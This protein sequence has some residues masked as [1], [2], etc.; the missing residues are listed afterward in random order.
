MK[1]RTLVSIGVALMLAQTCASAD[2]DLNKISLPPGFEIA[3]FADDV[4]N[5]RQMAWGESGT[6]FV[7]SRD[8]GTVYAV[9]DADGDGSA[10]KTYKIAKGLN[11]PSG[12]AFRQGSLYVAAVSTI[13][14]FDDIEAQLANPPKPVVVTDEF[15]SD[16]HHGWKYL[17]FGPDDKLYVPVGAP[18]NVCDEAGYSAIY[19]MDSDGKNREVYAEG[20]RNS[21]GFDWHPETQ[22]FWFSDNGRDRMGD[23][24]PPCEINFAPKPG[25]HFGFPYC[26]GGSVLD[27]EFGQGHSCDEFIAPAQPLQAH[28]APL[29]IAFYT[30]SEFPNAYEHGLFVAEHGSWNRSSKVGYRVMIASIDAQNNV[31]SYEP[32]AT[33]WLQGEQNWG[34]PADII[35][36]P[37][38]SLLVADDQAGVIYKISY[39]ISGAE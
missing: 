38:G 18:C 24:V 10:D 11:M 22:E 39:A 21:V 37:D 4:R 31:V 19:R 25:M 8:A 36:H 12:I 9:V 29:G 34:R 17:G 14:R 2:V 13:Y 28:V 27:P 30:G 7:G 16:R 3:I 33:G 32:F 20:V 5:A 23:D 15:P 26:H 1:Q 35:N 6:L